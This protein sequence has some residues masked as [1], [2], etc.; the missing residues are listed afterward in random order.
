MKKKILIADDNKTFLMYVGLLLKRFDFDVIPAETGLEVLKLVKLTEPDLVLLDVHMSRIDGVTVLR[1]LRE[2]QQTTHLSVIMISMDDAETTIQ[3]C[4]NLGCFDYLL[5]PIKIDKLHDSIQSCFFS[6]KGTNRTRLRAPY[7]VKV[8]VHHD[9]V[10]YEL[11][12]E[13]ISIG[14]IYLRKQEPL[15]VGSRVS[16]TLKLPDEHTIQ[17][18]GE[19]IYTKGLYGDFLRLPPGMAVAFKD[20]SEEDTERMRIFITDLLSRDIIEDQEE[21]IIDQ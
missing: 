18:N 12:S 15:P 7:T 9:N 10:D 8:S 20:L 13:S 17:T 14:G 2:D 1:H 11:F 6:H 21:T 5:K 19:V 3:Q 16:I 4:R